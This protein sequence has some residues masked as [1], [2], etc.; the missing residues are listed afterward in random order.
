[1]RNTEPDRKNVIERDKIPAEDDKRY[2]LL[3]W[4]LP[5]SWYTLRWS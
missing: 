5:F 3:R 4:Y 1:M 2:S